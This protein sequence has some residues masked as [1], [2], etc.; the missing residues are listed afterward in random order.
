MG[1][2][3]NATVVPATAVRRDALGPSVYVLEEVEENGQRKTRARKRSVRVASVP[4]KDLAEDLVVILEGLAVG[5]E[6]AAIGAF[7][8]RDGALVMPSEPNPDALLRPVGH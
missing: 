3:Q 7:K 8:L 6:I 1:V 5:E 2:L 4:S